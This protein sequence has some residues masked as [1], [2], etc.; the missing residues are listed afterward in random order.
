MNLFMKI[1]E[2]EIQNTLLYVIIKPF[3]NKL[4]KPRN[5][6]AKNCDS[7]LT[8]SIVETLTYLNPNNPDQMGF[9]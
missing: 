1:A 3:I 8:L 7:N 4:S 5:A 9:Q 6:N 2:K